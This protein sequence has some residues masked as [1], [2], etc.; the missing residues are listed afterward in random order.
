MSVIEK[1]EE[2]NYVKIIRNFCGI[3]KTKQN[4]FNQWITYEGGELFF[5]TMTKNEAI[6]KACVKFV[7]WY[8]ET[9]TI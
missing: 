2:T 7:K 8:N 3:N 1:I 5:S 6:F 4:E 9:K